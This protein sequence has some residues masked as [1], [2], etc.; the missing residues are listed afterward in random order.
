MSA[1]SLLNDSGFFLTKQGRYAEA[2][3]LYKQ[4]LELRRTALGEDHP[5]FAH[6]ATVQLRLLLTPSRP[7]PIHD[8][9]F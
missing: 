1:G 2:E 7:P 6:V 4:A 9:Y 8:W 5:D 3:P